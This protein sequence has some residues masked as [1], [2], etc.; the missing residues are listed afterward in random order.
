MNYN[1]TAPLVSVIV[2]NYNYSSFLK[3]RLDSVFNQ[4]YGNFE[5]ILLDD[6]STDNS[7]DMLK[8]YAKN[9]HTAVLEINEKNTQC[10][11]AQWVKGIRLA[12]GK[13]CWMPRLTMW[14]RTIFWKF[15]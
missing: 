8:E 15:A 5:V 14:L 12:K 11:F 2:P 4:T 6:A 10:P 1:N 7:V 9:E 3:A 13:Y